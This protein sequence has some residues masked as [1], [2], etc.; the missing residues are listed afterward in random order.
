MECWQKKVL[1]GKKMIE[2]RLIG[3][4]IEID[5]QKVARV[6]DISASM[7]DD[8]R[9]FIHKANNYDNIDDKVEDL[10]KQITEVEKNSQSA[11]SEGKIDGYAEGREHGTSD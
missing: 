3:N 5:N 8:L 2:I 1:K 11:Y 7:M 6:L 4:D 9:S 10:Q